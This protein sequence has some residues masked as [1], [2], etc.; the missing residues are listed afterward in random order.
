MKTSLLFMLSM[1]GM[2]LKSTANEVDWTAPITFIQNSKSVQLPI[3]A[4]SAIKLNGKQPI[5]L[6]VHAFKPPELSLS[7]HKLPV[8]LKSIE[9]L[10]IPYPETKIVKVGCQPTDSLADFAVTNLKIVGTHCEQK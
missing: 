10:F 3:H 2:P 1:M 7:V 5:L 9:E 4:N 6:R 8:K